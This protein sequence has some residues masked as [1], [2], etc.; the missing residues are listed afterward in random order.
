MFPA[1]AVSYA[2]AN[3]SL[4]PRDALDLRETFD[5]AHSPHI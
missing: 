2:N 3:I 4:S 1:P 5:N